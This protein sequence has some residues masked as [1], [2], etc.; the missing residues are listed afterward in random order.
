MI[1]K[2]YIKRIL[3][4]CISLLALIVLCPLIVVVTV[5]LYYANKGAGPFFSQERPGKDEKIFKLFKFK[6]MTDER[7]PNGNLLSDDKRL[8]VVGKFVRKTSLD[9]LPQLYNVLKGDMSL[10]GPRPLFTRYLSYY[11]AEEKIRHTV[12]PGITGWAQINGRNNLEWNKRLSMD[13][14]YVKNLSFT[15]DLKILFLTAY[16]VINRKDIVI[17]PGAKYKPLDIERNGN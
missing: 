5:W 2:N 12:R 9:E 4:I 14:F 8:T 11:T 6:S 10:I 7:D 15:L 1:Y 16:N 13:V 17:I 3:D